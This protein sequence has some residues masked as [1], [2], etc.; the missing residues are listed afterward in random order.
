M[1]ANQPSDSPAN[2]LL[3]LVEGH[4]VTAVIYAAARLGIADRLL[5]NPKSVSDLAH[6]TDTHERSLLR[7]MRALVKLAICTEAPDGKFKLTEMGTLLAADSERSLKAWV[8]LEGKILRASWGEFIESIRTG[9]TAA[10]LAGLGEER[11]E[12]L[13]KTKDAGLFNDAMVAMTRMAVPAVLSAYNFSG[14]STLMDVG[15]GLGELMSAILREY[16]QMRGIVFDLPH[17]AE[18][19]RKNLADAGVGNRCEFIEGSF[20]ESV[21]TGA[22]AIVMKSIIHDWNDERCVRILQNCHRALSPG[23]R[24]MLIDK[25]MPENLEPGARDLFVVLDDLNML[26]GPGGCERTPSEFRAVLEKGGFNMHRV[27]PTGRYSVIE[28]AAG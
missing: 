16:P 12:A 13:A 18:G 8:F 14:I 11:F 19:A 21:P 23:A 10:Q 26:R 3:N 25:V 2:V 27:V 28:A 15:G 22:D 4:R 5:Q 7:L 6:L 1:A 9:K 20:F 24:L 17:C